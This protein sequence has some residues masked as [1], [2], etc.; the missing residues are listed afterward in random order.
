ME[1]GAES[2][3]G[4]DLSD[5]ET[6]GRSLFI[7]MLVFVGFLIKGMMICAITSLIF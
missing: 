5:E 7:G 4:A 1:R 2:N 3:A 6:S